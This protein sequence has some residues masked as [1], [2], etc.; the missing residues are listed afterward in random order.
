MGSTIKCATESLQMIFDC[1][2]LDDDTLI[3][4]LI[5]NYWSMR[6]FK[7]YFTQSPKVEKYFN[8]LCTNKSKNKIVQLSNEEIQFCI[9]L[10]PNVFNKLDLSQYN[11]EQLRTFVNCAAKKGFDYG[12]DTKDMI[13][14]YGDMLTTRNVAILLYTASGY[15]SDLVNTSNKTNKKYHHKLSADDWRVVFGLD[16]G[17]KLGRAV[18][19]QCDIDQ[20]V[21]MEFF[22]ATCKKWLKYKNRYYFFDHLDD[23]YLTL[24]YIQNKPKFIRNFVDFYDKNMHYKRLSTDEFQTIWDKFIFNQISANT[25]STKIAEQC[26]ANIPASTKLLADI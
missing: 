24:N 6:R 2:N 19:L 16:E 17:S 26:G 18:N 11:E 15:F 14:E 20:D 4:F 8:F 3:K 23:I 12:W 21:Q 1:A 10:N 13:L 7:D 25:I 22:L 9:T 5:I